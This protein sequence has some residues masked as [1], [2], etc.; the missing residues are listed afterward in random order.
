MLELLE[1]D[2]GWD[3]Q[4]VLREAFASVKQILGLKV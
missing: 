2:K 1:Q 4:N 3:T